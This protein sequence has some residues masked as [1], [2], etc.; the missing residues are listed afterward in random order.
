M[1]NDKCFQCG[2]TGL[3]LSDRTPWTPCDDCM[4]EN[5]EL[6]L[7]PLDRDVQNEYCR[8]LEDEKNKKFDVLLNH[9]SKSHKI[10]DLAYFITEG[11]QDDWD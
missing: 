1:N 8:I 10:E 9:L 4:K 11:V 3:D 6:M 7:C 2:R 5:R